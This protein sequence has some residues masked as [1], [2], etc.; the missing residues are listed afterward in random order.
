MEIKP[1]KIK[2]IPSRSYL[3]GPLKTFT[4][5]T[6][7]ADAWQAKILEINEPASEIV[8]PEIEFATFQGSTRSLGIQPRNPL[9][10]LYKRFAA[11]IQ[12]AEEYILDTRY[13][14][15]GNLAHILTNV[16]PGL[17]AV[18]D[19]CPK[20]A[21][22]LRAK[23]TAMAKNT[24]KLLGFPVLCTDRDVIGKVILA[25][26]GADGKYEG[27]YASLFGSLA[28]EGFNRETPERV[29]ISRKGGRCLINEEEVEQV[30][31]EYGFRKFYYEDIP[32]SEQWS[33]AKNAKA[34]VGLHGA[35][36][37]TIVF[38]RN[39]VKVIELFHPGYVTMLYRRITYAVGGSWCGV[40]GQYPENI[41]K[42]L[43]YKHKARN[44]ALSSTH[45]DISSLRMAIEYL[46]IEKKHR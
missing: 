4:Y 6:R 45:I 9:R 39:A 10:R 36:L 14:I 33:I 19:K 35:A 34:L 17:L 27:W 13:D 28:F 15:D 24:Y 5:P 26:K 44:F 18:K 2:T 38:N 40:T 11:P 25:P 29:F 1:E 41:I 21:V 8:R 43:D 31:Q 3:L 46:G 7:L 32:L 30:L 16:A 22:I 20:I 12:M 23:A 37:A 42:E